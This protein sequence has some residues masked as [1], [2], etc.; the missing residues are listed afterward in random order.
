MWDELGLGRVFPI[1]LPF[2]ESVAIL[3]HW[4]V[5]SFSGWLKFCLGLRRCHWHQ[6][7]EFYTALVD[8]TLVG[9]KCNSGLADPVKSLASCFGWK[10]S[11]SSIWWTTPSSPWSIDDMRFWKCSGALKISNGSLLKPNRPIGVMKVVSRQNSSDKGSARIHCW[12]LALVPDSC[13]KVSSTFGSGWTSRRTPS[14]S[15]LRSTQI[16]MF[17]TTTMPAHQGVSTSTLGIT[18]CASILASSLITF[19]WWGRA[20]LQGVESAVCMVVHP[21][22]AWIWSWQRSSSVM[23]VEDR[24]DSASSLCSWVVRKF[25]ANGSRHWFLCFD[26]ISLWWIV[27]MFGIPNH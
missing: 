11:M 20:M 24:M 8:F 15:G 7:H 19:G 3:K 27:S 5:T 14:F 13:D 9:I 6:W 12:H 16:L 17:G 22:W 18:P 21:A 4:L 10:M 1:D 2:L 26:T 25:N 23:F